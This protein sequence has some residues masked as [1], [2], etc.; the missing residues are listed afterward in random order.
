M[1]FPLDTAMFQ[2]KQKAAFVWY[3]NIYTDT[4]RNLES[5]ILNNLEP[6][7]MYFKVQKLFKFP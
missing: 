3:F 2:Q 4:G 1:Q 6:S 7:G 5:E